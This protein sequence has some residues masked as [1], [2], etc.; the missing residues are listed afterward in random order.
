MNKL[1]KKSWIII[2]STLLIAGTVVGITI[3]KTK[4]AADENGADILNLNQTQPYATNPT[5]TTESSETT[6][7]ENNNNGSTL[8]SDTLDTLHN[9]IV[10]WD[11]DWADE[12][13]NVVNPSDYDRG[14]DEED[15]TLYFNIREDA[16]IGSALIDYDS[17]SI[18][19]EFIDLPI[20]YDEVV[21][22]FGE[23]SPYSVNSDVWGPD[24]IVTRF[25][26]MCIYYDDT[27]NGV[28]SI[29]FT[30]DTGDTDSKPLRECTCKSIIISSRNYDES[31]HNM[32][33]AIPGNVQWG[34]TYDDVVLNFNAAPNRHDASDGTFYATFEVEGG[35]AYTFRGEQ[36][37]LTSI[38]IDI[39]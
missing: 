31:A 30:F 11:D 25:T 12:D 20:S 22:K 7:S 33:I 24:D 16:N 8:D 9:T 32:T 6:P 14:A 18:N 13:P 3:Y 1:G 23:L 37:Q 35:I 39:S 4:Q 5:F 2:I 17:I 10:D 29:I 28:G 34:N 38:T 15:Q 26:T 27:V 36:H 19:G 21:N